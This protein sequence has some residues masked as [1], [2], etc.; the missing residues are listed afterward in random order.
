MTK[1]LLRLLNR[2]QAL[3]ELVPVLHDNPDAQSL[4]GLGHLLLL[5]AAVVA[6]HVANDWDTGTDGTQGP[7]L[8]VL[9]GHALS[10]LLPNDL[11]GVEVD[12]RVRLAGRFW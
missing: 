10:G 9:H 12:G 2:F 3:G 6:A 11:A 7:A 1:C 8:A 4:Q 5:L